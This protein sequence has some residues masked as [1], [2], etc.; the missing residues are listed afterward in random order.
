MDQDTATNL[1]LWEHLDPDKYSLASIELEH[2][3]AIV[4]NAM[5]QAGVPF[6]TEK[7]K[8]LHVH[9]IEEKSLVEDQLKKQFGFWYAPEKPT[10]AASVHMPKVSNKT[11]G[12][13][14]G[15]PYTK[16][17]I[18]EFN[19][20]SRPNI[21]KVL[22]DRGWKPTK[23]TD[24]GAPQ[25]D[26]EVLQSVVV[27]FPEMSGVDRYLMLDKRL[28]Q[29]ADGKQAWLTAVQDDGRIHG[30]INP[31]GTT[32]SRASHF[33]P[34]LGQVP[35]MASPYGPECRELFYA[36]KGWKFL[37]A[38]MSG[39]ELR[40]LAHYLQP[41]DGGLYMEAVIDGDIHWTNAQAMGLVDGPRDKSS[42]LHTII[43]ED[44]AKRF[45]YGFVY[46]AGAEKC[47]EIVFDCLIK[48]RRDCGPEGEALFNKVFINRKG[49]QRALKSVG[50]DVRDKFIQRIGG[51][52]DLKKRID[53]QVERYGWIY[54][55]DER[56]IPTRSAHS[57]LNF[58]IQSCGAILCKRWVC[59]VYE[60]L[61][62]KYKWGWDGDFV[63]CLWVHDEIQLCVREGLEEEIAAIIV[64][65]A[66][67]AGDSYGFR[68]PLDSS[69]AYGDNWR[70]TH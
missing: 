22:K 20:G 24:G 51:F 40:G 61:C 15:E 49:E 25:F 30:V 52:S 58:L 45:I 8:A 10:A 5:E 44:G 18:V 1:V 35:N 68:G 67:A 26:E 21:A 38:D 48:A 17:K 46:G 64:K 55:L 66:R 70:A 11:R 50:G 36:P 13:T 19:P 53:G 3:I 27:Q 65:H 43:R 16:L 2:R 7:A 29:L 31:M 59:D 23:F 4:C 47:G 57:A 69:Y 60:E 63:M 54:G 37:G 41:L 33:L 12:V 62:T 34:N 14:K 28:S 56:K 32:T 9:L 39:L 42:P 6:D